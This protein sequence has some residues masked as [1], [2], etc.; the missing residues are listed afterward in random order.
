MAEHTFD[1]I[2]FRLQFPAFADNTLFPTVVLEQ[3]WDWATCYIDPNDLGRWAG[4]CLQLALNL[5]TA[6]LTQQSSEISQG[7]NPYVLNGA[8][9]DK[10]SVVIQAVPAKNQW[11][12]WLSTTAYGQQLRALLQ[13]KSVGGAYVGGTPESAAFRRVGGIFW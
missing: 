5:M 13:V 1:P 8:T 10:V 12:L 7:Q 9:I 2:A 6:H 4:K 11:G 3:Y